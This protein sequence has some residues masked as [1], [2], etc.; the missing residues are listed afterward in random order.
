[1][2][3]LPVVVFAFEGMKISYAETKR[4]RNLQRLVYFAEVDMALVQSKLRTQRTV[5]LLGNL[6][7][8]F[9]VPVL[10]GL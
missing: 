10:I 1:M 5:K 7:K 6:V 3:V 8:P 2:F 4:R 9:D